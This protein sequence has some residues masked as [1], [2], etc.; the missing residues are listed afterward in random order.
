MTHRLRRQSGIER[1]LLGTVAA[2]IQAKDEI[3]SDLVSALE[4]MLVLYNTAD[5][6]N[7]RIAGQAEAAIANARGGEAK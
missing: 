6:Y 3:I 4:A 7:D 1:T 5:W 2:E